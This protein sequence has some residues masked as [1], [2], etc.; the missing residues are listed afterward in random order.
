MYAIRSYYAR[1]EENATGAGF[2]PTRAPDRVTVQEVL[3]AMR[4][5]LP[6]VRDEEGDLD[7]RLIRVLLGDLNVAEQQA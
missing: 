5:D 7:W 2:L 3:S 4:G 1:I 6:Q